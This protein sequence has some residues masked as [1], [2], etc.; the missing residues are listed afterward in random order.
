MEKIKEIWNKI[1]EKFKSFTK[2]VKIAIIVA[3]ITTIISFVSLFFYSSAN[4]YQVLFSNLE[5][6]DALVVSNRLKEL[7]IAMKIDGESILVDKSKV[8]ELRLEL[9]PELTGGSTGYELMDAS[10]SFGMT[11]EEFQ[12]KKLRMIQGELERTISSFKQIDKARVHITASKD[13]VFVEDKTP[14]KAAV[15]LKLVPGTKLSTEQVS[16]IIALV[17][18]SLSNTPKENIEVIDD[19]MNHLTSD[20]NKEENNYLG[21]E[22]IEKRYVLEKKY[23]E[24]LEKTITK[25]LE[26]VLGKDKTSV[27]VKATLDFDSKK[28]TETIID[29]NKVIVSQQTIY[30][31]NKNQ[32]AGGSNSPVDNNMTNVIDEN[33]EDGYVSSE[34]NTNYESGRKDTQVI[35]AP[36]EVKRLTATLFVDG[37]LNEDMQEAIQTAVGTA[38]GF[39]TDRG[40]EITVIGMTFDPLLK[41]EKEKEAENIK[42]ML[43]GGNNY[44]NY[45]IIGIIVLLT[46]IMALTIFILRRKKAKNNEVQTG[47]LDVVID[48]KIGTV[49]EDMFELDKKDEKAIMEEEIKKYA[50]EKPDQVVEI[51]K[52][53]L[54]EN[55]R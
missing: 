30:E 3:L 1:V 6:N 22:E 54:N 12:L 53:W 4:K 19:N 35:A 40:D 26:P 31:S 34:Q 48:D 18:G 47:M 25:L 23:N 46:I 28:Y 10:S 52:S 24:E 8:D 37:N 50:K 42:D 21:A 17:S 33:E 44:S 43:S 45:M 15:Y 20:L 14:G 5:S 41:E 32:I 51:V 27:S 9:A 7:G 16:S 49:T 2:T 55:E 11:D 29:P 39:N 36:G 13:S 38:I